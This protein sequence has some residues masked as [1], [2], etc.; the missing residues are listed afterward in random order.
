MGGLVG[1]VSSERGR[2]SFERGL[3]SLCHNAH[4]RAEVL[5]ESETLMVGA[6]YRVNT[7]PTWVQNL[8]PSLGVAVYGAALV[9]DGRTR[10]ASAALV[11]D[12][13][14]SLGASS[15]FSLDG[16]FVVAVI[17][18]AAGRL[19]L[20]NDRTGSIPV[21]VSTNAMGLAF[22]PEAKAVLALLGRSPRLDP[23]GAL[24]F[25]SCGHPLE[26]DSLFQDI[27]LLKPATVLSVDL[28]SA[29]QDSATYWN[30]SFSPRRSQTAKAASNELYE[31]LE[32]ARDDVLCD[33]PGSVD[34]LLTG[35][36]DSRAVSGLLAAGGM[37]PR[38]AMT[39]GI[40]P[41][42]PL[43]D[44]SIARVVADS[45]EIPFQFVR[46]GADTFPERVARWLFVS[47]LA[48]DNLGN[49]AGGADL[50]YDYGEPAD[51]LLLGDH[52]FGKGGIPF[53]RDDAVRVGAGLDPAVPPEGLASLLR[54][55]A[56]AEVVMW[57]HDAIDKRIEQCSSNH[58]KDIQDYLDFYVNLF[59]LL[60]SPAYFREPMVSPRRPLLLLP[61]LEFVQGLPRALRVDKTVLVQMVRRKQPGLWALPFATTNSLIDWDWEFTRPGP[62]REW[63]TL[64]LSA[65]SIRSLP[66]DLPLDPAQCDRAAAEYLD[67][68]RRPR[69]R[70]AGFRRMLPM[71]RRALAGA[72]SVGHAVRLAHL[73]AR[74]HLDRTAH[75]GRDVIVK[76]LAQLTMLQQMIDE[77]WFDRAG[78][79]GG[80]RVIRSERPS[81]LERDSGDGAVDV[82]TGF[83]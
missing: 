52:V 61:V 65:D 47:E 70:P 23:R 48:A 31:V 74:T 12:R 30:F 34:I 62:M 11:M 68:D 75:R 69:R 56:G 67:A 43:S 6:A 73:A 27:W 71:I 35:G 51:V 77:G 78:S 46:C 33:S 39:W 9:R 66:A 13:Y 83:E 36:L 60:E 63:M 3:L 49:C 29:K 2:P 14:R 82:G 8:S 26:G 64:R 54:G 20:V 28:V 37:R 10:A 57:T 16:T 25:L 80:T 19:V 7:P 38:R 22:A 76:R 32:G 15:L 58:P 45:C 4:F 21:Y 41:D 1:L 59:R 55:G 53:D 81:G 5:T 24:S 18:W 72:P 79:G 50:L 42:I 40:A 44:P 17:D